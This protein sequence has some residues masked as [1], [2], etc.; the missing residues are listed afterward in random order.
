MTGSGEQWGASKASGPWLRSC[1]GRLID[2]YSQCPVV[3]AKIWKV[4]VKV[5]AQRRCGWPSE[6]YGGTTGES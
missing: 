4:Q 3:S 6:E 1:P 5:E 2:R